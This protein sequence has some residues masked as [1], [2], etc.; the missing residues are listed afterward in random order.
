MSFHELPAEIF[1]PIAHILVSEVGGIKAFGYRNVNK[2]FAA[3]ILH[4]GV[5]HQPAEAFEPPD[6][7]YIGLTCWY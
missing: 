4:N 1:A 5:A 2:L 7:S 3:E 6:C